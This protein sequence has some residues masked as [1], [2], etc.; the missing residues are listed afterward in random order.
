M[1]KYLRFRFSSASLKVLKIGFW[2]DQLLLCFFMWVYVDSGVIRAV[3]ISW[4]VMSIFLTT[5]N[6]KAS[7]RSL[8]ILL[9]CNYEL[10]GA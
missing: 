5:N 6:I 10:L 8:I 2:E 1:E 3:I 9:L 4:I 7:A